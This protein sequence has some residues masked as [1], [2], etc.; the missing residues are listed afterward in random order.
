MG[1]LILGLIQLLTL[2]LKRKF[3][4]YLLWRI[5]VWMIMPSFLSH[6]VIASY[7]KGVLISVRLFVRS[8]IYIESSIKVHFL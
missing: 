3:P 5:V 7:N 2:E 4:V 6:M 1:G 8:T